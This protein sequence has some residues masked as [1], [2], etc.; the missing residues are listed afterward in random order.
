MQSEIPNIIVD[1]TFALFWELEPYLSLGKEFGYR[2]YVCTLENRHNG[3][4]IHGITDEQLVKMA[5][6][7]QIELLPERLRRNGTTD[8]HG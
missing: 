5:K 2:T 8:E 7:F 6:G 3:E 1:Q 4:N